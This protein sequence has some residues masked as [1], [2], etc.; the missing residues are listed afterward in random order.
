[1]FVNSI[2]GGKS[3]RV[4]LV[5]SCVAIIEIKCWGSPF[6]EA[7]PAEFVKVAVISLEPSADSPL[8]T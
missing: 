3:E 8:L 2:P 7:F 1:M 5:L 6:P 4:T